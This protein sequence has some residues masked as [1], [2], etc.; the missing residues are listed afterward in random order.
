MVRE[1]NRHGTGSDSEDD[2][3]ETP[4][5]KEERLRMLQD[6]MRA[7]HADMKFELDKLR[8]ARCRAPSK[9]GVEYMSKKAEEAKQRRIERAL[10]HKRKVEADE[11]LDAT[12]EQ[13]NAQHRGMMEARKDMFER[14]R[15]YAW[16]VMRPL[17]VKPVSEAEETKDEENFRYFTNKDGVAMQYPKQLYYSM[18][19]VPKDDFV[20]ERSFIDVFIIGFEGHIHG[21]VTNDYGGIVGWIAEKGNK[22]QCDPMSV[23]EDLPNCSCRKSDKN[24]V[25]IPV[26]PSK[27]SQL[28]PTWWM[29]LRSVPFQFVDGNCLTEE[30]YHEA[31]PTKDDRRVFELQAM[32]RWDFME[33][34]LPKW[35]ADYEA[36]ME[37][38]RTEKAAGQ[39]KEGHYNLP[40]RVARAL[41]NERKGME[42]LA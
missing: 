39:T 23:V 28:T 13:S 36:D 9:A 24:M 31:Y 12:M 33:S 6:N 30:S 34:N 32:E 7:R 4:E 5:Q 1:R 42:T 37:K 11:L 3:N 20:M 27:V 25:T 29:T 18:R 10:E 17:V 21:I 2:D 14:A 41:H 19:F 40:K 38:F 26:D 16:Q 22:V 8:R 35:K 15:R